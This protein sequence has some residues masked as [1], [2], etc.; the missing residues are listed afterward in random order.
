MVLLVAILI[1]TNQKSIYQNLLLQQ[2][3]HSFRTLDWY[4]L[5]VPLIHSYPYPR[6]VTQKRLDC[7]LRSYFQIV[8]AES[9]TAIKAVVRRARIVA[10][11]HSRLQQR[12]QLGLTFPYETL[13][14]WAIPRR[15][16]DT[17]TEILHTNKFRFTYRS[18]VMSG[19]AGGLNFRGKI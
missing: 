17:P 18:L 14:S 16:N 3:K 15:S 2:Q 1:D 10:Q 8:P 9:C 6:Y 7:R 11:L 12:F 5:Q 13:T 19:S 4:K